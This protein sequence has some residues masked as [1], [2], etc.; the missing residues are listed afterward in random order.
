MI[1]TMNSANQSFWNVDSKNEEKM[2]ERKKEKRMRESINSTNK[3]FE[4][5]REVKNKKIKFVVGGCA[6][7]SQSG[8]KGLLSAAQKFW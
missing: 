2:K 7:G 6:N 3:R 4:K 1:L 5:G 8:L